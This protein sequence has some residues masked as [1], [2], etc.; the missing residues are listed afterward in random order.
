[1]IYTHVARK[2]PT[3]VT[4]PL[5]VLPDLTPEAIDAAATASRHMQGSRA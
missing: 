2:G 3:G 1:M 4:S 5:D